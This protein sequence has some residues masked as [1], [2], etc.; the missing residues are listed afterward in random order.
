MQ[1]FITM[2]IQ[3]LE[4]RIQIGICGL[5]K[6]EKMNLLKWITDR[7]YTIIGVIICVIAVILIIEHCIFN[8]FG[9]DEW[10]GNVLVNAILSLG[11]IFYRHG[12]K[13]D[14]YKNY[15]EE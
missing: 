12:Q 15:S 9:I 13:K 7:R 4:L 8:A 6:I 3:L 5:S 1:I 2:G 11:I 14:A 10:F